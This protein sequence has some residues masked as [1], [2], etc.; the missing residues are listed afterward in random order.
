[1]SPSLPVE[2]LVALTAAIK[3]IL[4]SAIYLAV[5]IIIVFFALTK[6]LPFSAGFCFG[7]ATISKLSLDNS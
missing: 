1:M 5:V 3:H 6:K 2:V 7:T 4:H